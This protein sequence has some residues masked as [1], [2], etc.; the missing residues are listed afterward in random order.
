M[1]SFDF[2]R[3]L[4]SVTFLNLLKNRPQ[5]CVTKGAMH[6]FMN[7]YI[8]PLPFLSIFSKL[9]CQKVIRFL[10]GLQKT[11]D[12]G[13]LRI[14]LNCLRIHTIIFIESFP[15]TPIQNPLEKKTI[16][17]GIHNNPA[18]K[19]RIIAHVSEQF[20]KHSFFKNSENTRSDSVRTSPIHV[21]V[22]VLQHHFYSSKLDPI[23]IKLAYI[24]F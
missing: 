17:Q 5:R 21:T 9:T 18:I 1:D 24:C 8:T 6:E 14:S 7:H 3:S 2:N 10:I 12:A 22:P 20:E 4:I 11:I 13:Q 15:F 23:K 19:I 16:K